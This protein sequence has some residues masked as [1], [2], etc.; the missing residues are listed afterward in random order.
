MF[1]EYRGGVI[2]MVLVD[3]PTLPTRYAPQRH[4][5]LEHRRRQFATNVVVTPS[6]PFSMLQI[7]IT[8][9]AVSGG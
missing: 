9:A 5:P 7:D 6:T 3:Q 4:T 8:W 2:F 1:R